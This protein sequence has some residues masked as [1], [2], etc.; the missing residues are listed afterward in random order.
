MNI[1]VVTPRYNITGVPL[2]QARF[3]AALAERGHQVTLMIGRCDRDIPVPQVPGVEVIELGSA[4]VRDMLWPLRRYLRNAR[5]DVVFSAEDHLNCMVAAAA[6]LARSRTRISGSSRVPPFDTYSH[7]WFTKRWALKQ[8]MRALAWRI[9][10]LT[11]VSQDMVDLYGEWFPG[12]GHQCVYNIVDLPAARERMAEPLDDPWFSDGGPIPIVA[13][14]SLAPYKGFA[15]LIRAIA[16]VPEVRLI[17][18]GE[19]SQRAELEALIA[20]LGLQDRVRLHGRVANPLKY[21]ARARIYALSSY[22]EGMPNVLVE[23][24]LC[25]CTPVATDCRTGPREL[26]HD[27]RFGYLATVGDPT[28]IAAALRA[29]MA[30]PIPPELLAEAVRP[31]EQNRVI[32]RH[33]ALLG[34]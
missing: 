34:L 17:I 13:A 4:Q 30:D 16:L 27:G 24:M 11:C 29:A 10:V 18:L 31:F 20:Q 28:S 12:M 26:L 7:R 19:G 6:L 25:G 22:A 14:G 1:L 21:F 5:P 15:D 33:F 8:V 2:A 32:D 23:A 3:A 9:D